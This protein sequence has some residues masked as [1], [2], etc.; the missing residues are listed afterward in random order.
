M[1]KTKLHR[2]MKE[3]KMRGLSH[4]DASF[5]TAACPIGLVASGAWWLDLGH[6]RLRVSWYARLTAFYEVVK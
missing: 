1:I 6:F 5:K 2:E 4:W 3:R